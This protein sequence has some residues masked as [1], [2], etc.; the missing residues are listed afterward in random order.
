[1]SQKRPKELTNF[2]RRE[3]HWNWFKMDPWSVARNVFHLQHPRSPLSSDTLVHSTFFSQKFP[4]QKVT[5][6]ARRMPNYESLAWPIGMM[7]RF[8]DVPSILGNIRGQEPLS[9]RITVMAAMEDK[10]MGVRLMKE[11]ASEYRNGVAQLG[12]EKKIEPV[13]MPPSHS[14]IS[15]NVKQSTENGIT[16]VVVGGAGHH[17]QN[18]IRAD[19][20]A[21]ALKIFLEQL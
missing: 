1:M 9:S 4:R 19:E 7:R 21:E 11:V 15:K 5:K 8:T 14:Q 2:C 3:V 17:M 20:A 6:F 10:L 13:K 16:M 12:S 18:K